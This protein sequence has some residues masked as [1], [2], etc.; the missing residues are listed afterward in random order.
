MRTRWLISVIVLSICIIVGYLYNA[1]SPMRLKTRI[2][3][4]ADDQVTSTIRKDNVIVQQKAEA[5]PRKISISYSTQLEEPTAQSSGV[6]SA[7]S[8]II[9]N[10]DQTPNLISNP[11]GNI[12]N[13]LRQQGTI[14]AAHLENLEDYNVG[15]PVTLEFGQQSLKGAIRDNQ[16]TQLG[17]HSVTVKLD[18]GRI[19]ELLHLYIAKNGKVTG[20]LY[21]AEGNYFI[22]SYKG[23]GFY[24]N[25][26]NYR[27]LK[28]ESFSE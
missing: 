2:T 22:Q 6:S 23:L 25:S 20:S 15:E 5:T 27:R 8:Q 12:D 3:A 10:F 1:N 16:V 24:M 7:T 9:I 11:P 18:D 21:T 4:R 19:P 26:F 28:N 13:V 17:A 14:F